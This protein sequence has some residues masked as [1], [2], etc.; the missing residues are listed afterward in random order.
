MFSAED[1]EVHEHVNEWTQRHKVAKYVSSREVR[2]VEH[3][4]HGEK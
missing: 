3:K 2:S 4:L 1:A